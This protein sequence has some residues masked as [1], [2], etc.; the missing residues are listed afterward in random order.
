MLLLSNYFP[1]Y[2]TKNECNIDL[3]S[4]CNIGGLR[5]IKTEVCGINFEKNEVICRDGRPPIRFDVLSVNIGIKPNLIDSL[6]PNL[7]KSD[8]VTAVKPIDAFTRT[9][10]DFILRT[11]QMTKYSRISIAIVGGGAGG[12]EV[13]FAVHQ[14]LNHNTASLDIKTKFMVTLIT[15]GPR[16]LPDHNK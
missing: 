9:W 14:R 16:L 11:N 12:V 10:D 8:S 4:L 13:A 5:F 2:Y 3:I 1:G 7:T 6:S 15:S